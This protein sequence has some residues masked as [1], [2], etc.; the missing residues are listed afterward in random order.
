MSWPGGMFPGAILVVVEK[1][2][3]EQGVQVARCVI[4]FSHPVLRER[5]FCPV[6]HCRRFWF[7]FVLGDSVLNSCRRLRVVLAGSVLGGGSVLTL[8]G[9]K[10]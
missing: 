3:L 6:C 2:F 8:T 1:T 4:Y 5:R 10:H 7:L 9:S